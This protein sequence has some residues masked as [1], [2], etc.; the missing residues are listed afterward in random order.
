VYSLNVNRNE[1]EMRQKKC[2]SCEELLSIDQFAE[3]ED[4]WGH[5]SWCN[6][7]RELLDRKNLT[8]GQYIYTE[9]TR[10]FHVRD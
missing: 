3:R 5:Y 7:C 4:A 1:T 9:R 2:G 6:D 8:A 10:L